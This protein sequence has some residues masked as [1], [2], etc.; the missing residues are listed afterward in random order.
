M[1]APIFPNSWFHLRKICCS[2]IFPIRSKMDYFFHTQYSQNFTELLLTIFLPKLGRFCG[3]WNTPCW[4][5]YS[6]P[7]WVEYHL[8]L[9]VHIDIFD[10]WDPIWWSQNPSSFWQLWDNQRF[11]VLHSLLALKMA[12]TLLKNRAHWWFY[13]QF[14]NFFRSAGDLLVAFNPL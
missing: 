9:L 14:L 4:T 3:F 12:P 6:Y 7:K 1:L 2:V 13:S 10:L 5:T 11:L 8:T